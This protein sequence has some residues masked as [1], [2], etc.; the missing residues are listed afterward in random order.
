MNY[1]RKIN[2]GKGKKEKILENGEQKEKRKTI[3]ENK[4]KK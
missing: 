1:V 3:K 2:K 4:R